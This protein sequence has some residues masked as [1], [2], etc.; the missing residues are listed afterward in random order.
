MIPPEDCRSMAELRA[1]IDALDADLVA[2]LALRARYIDR[3]AELKPA[4]GLPARIGPRIDEVIGKVRAGA[5]D[6]GLDPDLVERVWRELIEWAIR[7][8]E[9]AMGQ[10]EER[11]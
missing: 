9:V 10:R 3:A 5:E 7:R 4:E 8:E 2:R 1:Q 11:V 6:E